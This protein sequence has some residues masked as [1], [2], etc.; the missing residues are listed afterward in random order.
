[1]GLSE[2]LKLLRTRKGWTQEEAADRAGVSKNALAN[3]E[4]GSRPQPNLLRQ[5]AEAYGV[6]V[7]YLT[8][9]LV[10]QDKTLFGDETPPPP[11]PTFKPAATFPGIRDLLA[12]S[13][14]A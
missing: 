10:K 7:E 8:D 3:W 2:R 5:V 14:V 1:M 12:E 6:S 4:R 11:A 13:Y 9:P